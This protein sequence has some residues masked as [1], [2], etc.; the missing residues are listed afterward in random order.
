MPRRAGP[1][2][3]PVV[4]GWRLSR[5]EIEQ[6]FGAN[7]VHLASHARRPGRH[8]GLNRLLS[9]R[10]GGFA[11]TVKT[12]AACRRLAGRRRGRSPEVRRQHALPSHVVIAGS[13]ARASSH[14]PPL[15]VARVWPAANPLQER[16]ACHRRRE[17]PPLPLRRAHL[18]PRR[19]RP[20]WSAS[21]RRRRRH[22]RSSRQTYH[23]ST[24]RPRS[25]ARRPIATGEP[26]ALIHPPSLFATRARARL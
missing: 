11:P 12:G 25:S 23:T 22:R 2:R 7:V 13:A 16:W 17:C 21:R 20:R 18:P 10:R 9:A 19:P 4:P 15:D 6:I 14:S 3:S 24:G 26:D 5:L 8:R 1:A